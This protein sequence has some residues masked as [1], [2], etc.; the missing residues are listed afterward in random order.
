MWQ[1]HALLICSFSFFGK[2]VSVLTVTGKRS[3]DYLSLMGKLDLFI[4]SFIYLFIYFILREDHQKSLL[5]NCIVTYCQ[6]KKCHW[7]AERGHL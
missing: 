1:T 2:F 5:M 3:P 7:Y 4:Y 6:V